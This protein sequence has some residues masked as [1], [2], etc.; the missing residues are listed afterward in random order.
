MAQE[1]YDHDIMNG[2]GEIIGTISGGKMLVGVDNK[3]P[4][5]VCGKRDP[6]KP[7][8]FRGSPFCCENHRKEY[9]A[10]R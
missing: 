3:H 7:I 10:E 9:H 1:I 4:C 2:L 6:D 5:L 8:V